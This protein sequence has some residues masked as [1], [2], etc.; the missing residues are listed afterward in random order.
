MFA[1]RF[2]PPKRNTLT[3][4]AAQG[5]L[6]S[7]LPTSVVRDR[8][9]VIYANDETGRRA[10]Y[11]LLLNPAKHAQFMMD[12]KRHASINLSDYGPIIHSGYGEKLPAQLR[13]T[14]KEDYGWQGN[15]DTDETYR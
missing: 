14:L 6:P 13:E 8:L 10:Y 11:C 9:H 7:K 3:S 12:C 2:A 5:V 4:L 15:G 1:T